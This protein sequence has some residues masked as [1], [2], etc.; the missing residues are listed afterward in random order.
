MP[1]LQYYRLKA[2]Y[3]N[4]QERM[5]YNFLII[6]KIDLISFSTLPLIGSTGS[7][8]KSSGRSGN[9][10]FSSKFLESKYRSDSLGKTRR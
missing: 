2:L 8:G 3:E 7:D 5:K 4:D 1:D 6:Y 9:D 10:S